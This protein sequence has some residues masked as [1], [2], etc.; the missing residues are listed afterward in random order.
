MDVVVAGL[1]ACYFEARS[2][3]KPAPDPRQANQ[4]GLTPP[5]SSATHNPESQRASPPGRH[6]SVTVGG[7][8]PES[9]ATSYR[10]YPG[11]FVVIGSKSAKSRVIWWVTPDPVRVTSEAALTGAIEAEGLLGQAVIISDD[12]GQFRVGDHALCWVHAER[13]VHKLVPANDKQS[14]AVKVAKGMIWWFYRRLKAYKRAPSARNKQA[15]CACNS[16]A[17]SSAAPAMRRSTVCSSASSGEKTNFC[18]CS[19]ERKSRSTPTPRK[20]TSAPS[21]PS[22]KSPAER[23][24]KGPPSPRRHARPRQDLQ[25]T[26]N[27]LLRLSRRP[28]RHPW[29]RHPQPRDPRQP[30]PKLTNRPESAPVTRHGLKPLI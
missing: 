10:L 21:S 23:Q 12:A 4:K 27:P 19:K 9:R 20:T 2:R 11:G 29:P 22:A 3:R 7:I 16:I 5:A 28:S 6:H 30:R 1:I 14:N 25:E 24:R 17:S 18:A 15:S 8:I 26:Q 13:L